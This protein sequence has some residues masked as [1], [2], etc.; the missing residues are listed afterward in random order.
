[1]LKRNFH[2]YTFYEDGTILS[3]H[4][5]P[6][7]IRNNRG[8][9][10]IK[11]VVDGKRENFLVSRLMYK[12]FVGF[13]MENKDLCVIHKDDDKLNIHINN[14]ALEHRKNLIQGDKH[15]ISK[16]TNEQAAEIR[17]AYR[18]KKGVNQHDKEGLSMNDLAKKYGVT[19]GQIQMIV[20][21]WS[22]DEDSYK[23]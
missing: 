18:N 16:L 6:M 19:K 13:D 9:K 11:L 12:L 8:R 3:L 20:K 21:G 1:M 17:K 5:R 2:G 10:E 7:K 14:L 23:L 4:G 15:T 22:R